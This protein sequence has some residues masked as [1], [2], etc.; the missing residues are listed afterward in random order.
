LSQNI[1]DSALLHVEKPKVYIAPGLGT[2]PARD[3]RTDRETKLPQLIRTIAIHCSYASS[4][5]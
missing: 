2:L 5:A 4:R 3:G 1:R